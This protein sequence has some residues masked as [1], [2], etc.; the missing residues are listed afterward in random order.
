M[1]Y[2]GQYA[3]HQDFFS[4]LF[5]RYI[6]MK[7]ALKLTGLHLGERLSP[8]HHQSPAFFRPRSSGHVD[9]KGCGLASYWFEEMIEVPPYACD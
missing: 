4:L 1:E 5:E 9:S 8:L 3:V 6:S 2:V 7:P